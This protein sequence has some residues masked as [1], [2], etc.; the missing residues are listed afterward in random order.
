MSQSFA[1]ADFAIT[2]TIKIIGLT[3]LRGQVGLTT[4]WI[5]ASMAQGD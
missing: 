3:L 2:T 5:D 4:G 1:D